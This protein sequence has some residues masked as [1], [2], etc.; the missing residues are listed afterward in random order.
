VIHSRPTF[1]TRRFAPVITAWAIALS[2]VGLI[3]WFEK[4]MPAF[5]EVVVPLYWIIAILLVF[6]T[7]RWV[8]T[9]GKQEHDRRTTDRRQADR[10]ESTADQ[11]TEPPAD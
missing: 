9:R 8:R 7:W 1:F 11:P 5:H 6:G 10:R 4:S 3:Y 2:V